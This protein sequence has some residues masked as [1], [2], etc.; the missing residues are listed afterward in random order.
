M[1]KA[2]K[3]GASPESLWVQN[4]PGFAGPPQANPLL[5]SICVFLNSVTTRASP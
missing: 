2:K 4:T 3:R 5:S 1:S